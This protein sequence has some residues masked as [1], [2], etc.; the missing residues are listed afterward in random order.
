MKSLALVLAAAVLPAFAQDS[1]EYPQ[2]PRSLVQYFGFTTEQTAT[3]RQLN[4]D[5]MFFVFDQWDLMDELDAAASEE[6]EKPV[7]DPAEV[8]KNIVE[9]EMVGRSISEKFATT[10]VAVQ[11]VLT[12]EQKDKLKVLQ[13]A[14]KLSGTVDLATDWALLRVSGGAGGG[15][16]PLLLSPNRTIAALAKRSGERKAQAR[17][18]LG[19]DTAER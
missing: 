5:L 6:L 19:R 12:P 11:A 4:Q 15:A 8:G 2:M 18:L 3:I 13:D 1:P 10:V 7:P 14:A 9:L 16:V 17:R